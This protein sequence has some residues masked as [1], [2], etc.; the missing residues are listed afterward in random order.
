MSELVSYQYYAQQ[1]TGDYR[2][3]FQKAEM[4]AELKGLGETTVDEA[5]MELVDA[6]LEAQNAGKP[7]EKVLGRD[8]EKFCKDYFNRR[9]KIADRLR[10]LLKLLYRLGIVTLVIE[11]LALLGILTDGGW[12]EL[13]SAKTDI[14]GYL[15]GAMCGFLGSVIT[16][17]C[18]RP[19]MFRWKKLSAGK[20]VFILC[21]V[22][23]LLSIPSFVWF[24]DRVVTVPMLPLFL[25]VLIYVLGFYAHKLYGRYKATGSIKKTPEEKADSVQGAFRQGLED[26]MKDVP[27]LMKT[28]FER[29][30]RRRARRH[31]EPLTPEEFMCLLE[32]EFR[33]SKTLNRITAL[34]FTLVC[35]AVWAVAELPR[36]E[37]ILDSFLGL[38][39]GIGCGLAVFW[40][41]TG[42]FSQAEA[43]QAELILKC[44]E[45]GIT[46]LDLAEKE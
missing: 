38:A 17:C 12:Q 27:R 34:V 43:Q 1:L 44:R 23:L 31:R 29:I 45:K 40:L 22:I 10:D 8:M 2:A 30:N 39:V 36:T 4:Y 14:N 46:V 16:G 7:V 13:V 24:H 21:A 32:K 19:L 25:I 42:V 33:R 6:L 15:C 37:D 5:M 28:R 20:Y 9:V 35:L 41:V 26:G 11:G 18:L 3:A